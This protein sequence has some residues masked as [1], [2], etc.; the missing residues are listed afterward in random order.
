MEI[1]QNKNK[2][3]DIQWAQGL[4]DELDDN[5][6]KHAWEN[7]QFVRGFT[8]DNYT[9]GSWEN[10]EAK[11]WLNPQSWAVLSGAARPDQAKLSMDKV[12]ENLRTDYGT[13]LFYPP[14]REYGL[15]VALM[16]LFN[17]ST[18]ENGGIFSQPQGWL[19]LAETM[20]GNGRRA[21]EYFLNCSPASMNDKA[22]IRKLEPYVHGQFVESKDSPYQGRAHVHWLT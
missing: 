14:F 13:M 19:I 15:P 10:D 8:E 3:E 7:D 4:L 2:P 22:E 6:Q 5:I 1:A 21:F 17:A 16:A 12:Y 11:I 20:I 18:K 9:I